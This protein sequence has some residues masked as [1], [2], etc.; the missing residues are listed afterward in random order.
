[1]PVE[2]PTAGEGTGTVARPGAESAAPGEPGSGDMPYGPTVSSRQVR[3]RYFLRA[4]RDYW[5][6]FRIE[7]D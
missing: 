2:E 5:V 3:E 4:H 1:V 7:P 6:I